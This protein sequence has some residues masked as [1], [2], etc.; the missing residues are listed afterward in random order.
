MAKR[1]KKDK[2]LYKVIKKDFKGKLSVAKIEEQPD[3]SAKVIFDVDDDFIEWFKDW[4]GM[5]R[6]SRKRFETVLVE[7]LE[8]LM[9]KDKKK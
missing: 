4:Q 1:K 3:G 8:N 2:N 5:K 7:A 6:W 9:R